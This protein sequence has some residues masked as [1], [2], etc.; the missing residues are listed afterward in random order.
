MSVVPSGGSIDT[1][2]L[3]QPVHKLVAEAVGTLTIILALWITFS[4]GA[5]PAW[6]RGVCWGAV[7]IVTAETFLG[8]AALSTSK[9]YAIGF[10]HA[11]LGHLFVSMT[12]ALALG[13]AWRPATSFIA[14]KGWP[15]LRGYSV[16]TCALVVL[17]VILGAAFRHE[18]MGVMSHIIGALILALFILGLAMLVLNMPKE[19]LPQGNPLKVPAI[20]LIVLAGIQVALGLTVASM[21]G[22]S[23]ALTVMTISH[24][25][26]GSMTLASTVVLTVLIRQHMRRST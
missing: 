15:S 20:V 17:Q 7:A 19:N 25:A 13:A 11:L 18:L 26:I 4:K 1:A 6:L 12:A 23:R 21:G 16:F 9:A 3:S 2:L 24:A 10:W 5:G 14:D 8:M 22:R